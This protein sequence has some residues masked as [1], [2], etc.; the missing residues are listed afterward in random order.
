[1][2]ICNTRLYKNKNINN[3]IVINNALSFENYGS[4][5]KYLKN[6]TVKRNRN[7]NIFSFFFQTIIF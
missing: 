2:H 6:M 1:M 3:K 4:V 5:K 7:I